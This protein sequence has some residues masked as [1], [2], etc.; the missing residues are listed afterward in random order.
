MGGG[1]LKGRARGGGGRG[2]NF[3]FSVGYY[4]MLRAVSYG[5]RRND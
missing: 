5:M 2:S 4:V 3:N 1:R